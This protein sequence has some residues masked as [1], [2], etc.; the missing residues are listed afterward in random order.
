MPPANQTRMCSELA[1]SFQEFD[2]V[3]TCRNY[4]PHK[5]SEPPIMRYTIRIHSQPSWSKYSLSMSSSLLPFSASSRWVLMHCQRL[6]AGS[7]L[8]A[9]KWDL[10]RVSPAAPSAHWAIA[11]IHA[12]NVALERWECLSLSSVRQRHACAIA[13]SFHHLHRDS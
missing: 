13:A 10:V 7:P 4:L 8:N 5:T 6:F 11:I 12:V 1:L 3:S 2:F 9:F